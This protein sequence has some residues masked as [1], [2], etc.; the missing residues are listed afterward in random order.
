V[1]GEFEKRVVTLLVMS[2]FSNFPGTSRACADFRDP[3]AVFRIMVEEGGF[4]GQAWQWG[5]Q[6]TCSSGVLRGR[7]AANN[8]DG[9][10]ESV[11][12][13]HFLTRLARFLDQHNRG[14]KKIIQSLTCWSV[15]LKG[16]STL[17]NQC[18]YHK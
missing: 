13:P 18:H 16:N 15:T 4:R 11:A 5:N 14:T 9:V 2:A 10:R 1:H 8:Y 17:L 3:T 7:L 6:R 12:L